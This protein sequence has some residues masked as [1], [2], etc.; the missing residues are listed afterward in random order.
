M[1]GLHHD[2]WVAKA[3]A[4]STSQ[5]NSPLSADD[6]MA[7]VDLDRWCD[8]DVPSVLEYLQSNKHCFMPDQDAWS[9][10]PPV[11]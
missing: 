1:E 5:V 8:A 2:H 10:K 7:A 4:H 6:L 3:L 9:M 11:Q